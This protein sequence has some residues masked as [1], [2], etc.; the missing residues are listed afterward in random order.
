M[1][2]MCLAH[3]LSW[4]L[5]S[6]QAWAVQADPTH[7][8]LLE[9][10][11]EWEAG[12]PD[13]CDVVGAEIQHLQGKVRLQLTPLHAAN[14]VVL[15]KTHRAGESNMSFCKETIFL[16]TS[17]HFFPLQFQRIT[18]AMTLTNEVSHP[19]FHQVITCR[20]EARQNIK[21][22]AR[23]KFVC[24]SSKPDCSPQG[25]EHGSD[26]LAMWRAAWHNQNSELTGTLSHKGCAPCNE[27]AFEAAH[28]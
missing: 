11:S 6:V 21:F 14:P 3:G 24:P 13:L 23:D 25:Q 20:P 19:S 4:A 27:P 15:P 17:R 5:T 7:L 10:Q 2:G 8:Q 26:M 18:N 22:F 12:A 9:G 28:V 16:H 1:A